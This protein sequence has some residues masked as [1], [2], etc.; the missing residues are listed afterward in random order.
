MNVVSMYIY[1]HYHLNE[2]GRKKGYLN[3]CGRKK[4]ARKNYI[5]ERSEYSF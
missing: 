5:L 2:C 1:I 3:E 4:K